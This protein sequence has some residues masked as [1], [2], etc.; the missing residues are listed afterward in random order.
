MPRAC[1][2]NLQ[3]KNN[4]SFTLNLFA[5]GKENGFQVEYDKETKTFT[6]D[7]SGLQNQ[8]N[9][10]YGTTRKINGIEVNDLLIFIDHSSAEIFVNDGEYVLSSRIFPTLQENLLR[11][12]GR[13]IDIQIYTVKR[14]CFIRRMYGKT[15]QYR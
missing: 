6:I 10:Q 9:T 8:L 7:R 4:Q 12:G 5:Q 3:N 15:F 11:L 1:V 13:D 2:L 14:I